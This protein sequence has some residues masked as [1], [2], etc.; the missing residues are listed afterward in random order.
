MTKEET[1]RIVSQIKRQYTFEELQLMSASVI[2]KLLSH[3]AV[4]QAK[5]ILFYY[6]LPDEVYTHEAINHLQENGKNVYLPKILGKE[7]VFLKYD[8]TL[9]KGKYGIMEPTDDAS[10]SF[11]LQEEIDN[12]D[13][14]QSDIRNSCDVAVIPGVAFDIEGNRLGRGGGYYDRYFRSKPTGTKGLK[15]IGICFPFQLFDQIPTEPHDLRV[16]DVLF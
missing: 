11:Y 2:S 1:R 9:E 6:S 8:E 3:P 16:D 14:N 7:M 10:P 15:L 13:E 4:Q 12:R 5:N